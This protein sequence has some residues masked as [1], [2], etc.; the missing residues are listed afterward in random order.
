MNCRVKC[1]GKLVVSGD[2]GRVIGG[3]M[4]LKDG[5]L[6][7]QVG[8]ERGVETVISFGQD[9]LVENQIEQVRNEMKKIQD[10]IDKTDGMMADLE[11][12]PGS[13]NKLI[14]IRG[15][16]VDALKMLE[17]KNL[18]LFLLREKY[19]H[20]FDS[21]VKVTGT[22]YSGVVFESHGRLLKVEDPIKAVQISFNREK[23]RLEKKPI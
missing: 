9:Y 1:N 7:N 23:G 6:C 2:D 5:L 15:K 12:K 17:K 3:V 10:F 18:R 21:E 19:E 8:N 13:G 22:A 20:H 16:K 11:K 4:K 14:M